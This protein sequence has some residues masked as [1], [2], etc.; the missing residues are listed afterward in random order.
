M[1]LETIFQGAPSSVA[2][3]AN[4][5]SAGLDVVNGVEYFISGS[6]PTW[7][8]ITDV[9]SKNQVLAQAANNANVINYTVPLSALYEIDIHEISTNTPTAATLP[10]VTA[11]YTDADT[12]ASATAT[13]ATV[14]GVNAAN[15]V[16][17]GVLVVHPKVGTNLVIATTGYAAGSGAALSYNMY[18]RVS[19]LG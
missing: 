1:G 13:L 7:T 19:Y 5:N 15:V 4:T 12:G 18:A 6:V 17:N 9:V 10:S 11:T 16:N 8:P 2:T 14:T 3:P